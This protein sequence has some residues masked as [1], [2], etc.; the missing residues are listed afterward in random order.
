MLTAMT[1]VMPMLMMMMRLMLVRSALLQKLDCLVL[2]RECLQVAT[3]LPDV[4]LTTAS[5][6]LPLSWPGHPPGLQTTLLVAHLQASPLSLY[7]PPTPLPE[8][9]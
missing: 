8:H 9:L 4:C 6:S 7:P 5:P 3:W 2:P 1:A